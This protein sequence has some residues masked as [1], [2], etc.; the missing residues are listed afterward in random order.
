MRLLG[1]KGQTIFV[2]VWMPVVSQF[3][4]DSFYAQSGCSQI[5]ILIWDLDT[6]FEVW[7]LDPYVFDTFAHVSYLSYSNLIDWQ[8][9]HYKQAGLYSYFAVI[10]FLYLICSQLLKKQ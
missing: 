9:G 5:V 7:T 2:G 4:L 8:F 1:V 10:L 3:G 6:V